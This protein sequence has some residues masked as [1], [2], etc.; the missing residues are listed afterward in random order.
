M[1]EG[2]AQFTYIMWFAIERAFRLR[3]NCFRDAG[4]AWVS[5]II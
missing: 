3:Q 1:V 5:A 4:A 2:T